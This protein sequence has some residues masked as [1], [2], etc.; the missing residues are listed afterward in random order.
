MYYL[1]V[2]WGKSK[3]GL[4]IADEENLIASSYKQVSEPD[5]YQ[6]ILF[7][8]RKESIKKIILG[9]HEDL[10]REK[11]FRDFLEKIKE[12]N[13]ELELENEKFSTQMAQKNLIKAD[14]KKI[15]QIDDVESARII[16]QGW[17]DKNNS[18]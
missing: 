12:L 13:I 15:S 14:R 8:S 9:F 4:A 18:K 10:K 11:K 5:L 1:G 16:L 7:F 2:D 6:E 3:C 17:L